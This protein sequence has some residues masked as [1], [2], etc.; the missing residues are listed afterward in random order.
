MAVLSGADRL[1]PENIF[2]AFGNLARFQFGE[3]LE[4]R[5]LLFR[6]AG[7]GFD[8]DLNDLIAASAGAQGGDAFTVEAE[9]VA[10]LGPFGNAQFFFHPPG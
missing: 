6:Q 10:V 2:K 9:D 8:D 4:Q 5:L 1:T 7:G 3:F